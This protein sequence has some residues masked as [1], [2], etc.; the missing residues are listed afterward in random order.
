VSRALQFEDLELAGIG[1]VW[2]PG[3]HS[4]YYR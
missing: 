2:V 3:D 4:L 1:G